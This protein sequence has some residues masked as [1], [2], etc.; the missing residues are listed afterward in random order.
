MSTQHP[1]QPPTILR[2]VL[3]PLQV[4]TSGGGG[5][6]T[7]SSTPLGAPGGQVAGCSSQGGFNC[8]KFANISDS[9]AQS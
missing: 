5:C 9:A 8:T 3:Q 4:Q 1:Y 7:L 2:V 6:S